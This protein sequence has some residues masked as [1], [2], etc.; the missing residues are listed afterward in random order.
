MS[1]I[2]TE[3][4]AQLNPV[5][6]ENTDVCVLVVREPVEKV[7]TVMLLTTEPSVLVLLTSLETH[8]PGVTQSAPATMTAQ[9]TKLV[10]SSNAAIHAT[11]PTLM[12]AGRA[13][14]ARLTIT[15][16]CAPV[17]RAT[18]ET[19]LSAVGSLRREICVTQ[20]PVDLEPAVRQVLTD[21]VLTGQCAPAQLDTGEIL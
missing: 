11:I 9:L 21:L 5:T 13:L 8:I 12:Y 7:L 15:R 3:N 20:V 19:H 18:P 1:V 14:P 6:A 2:L 10:S 16:L 17:P 4:V